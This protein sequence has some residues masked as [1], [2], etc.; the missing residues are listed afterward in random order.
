MIFAMSYLVTE[1]VE[2]QLFVLLRESV[3]NW[4]VLLTI[5]HCLAKKLLKILAFYLK[6]LL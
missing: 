3:G 1:I 6:S 2:R 4:L 5:V